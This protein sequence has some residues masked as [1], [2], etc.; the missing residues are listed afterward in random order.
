MC[1]HIWLKIIILHQ[2]YSFLQLTD[3]KANGPY[4]VGWYS[5]SCRRSFRPAMSGHQGWLGMAD[6]LSGLFRS[7]PS[8]DTYIPIISVTG[9]S[10]DAFLS[11]SWASVLLR[12]D[13]CS[14]SHQLCSGRFV[15]TWEGS[16]EFF[17]NL[18]PINDSKLPGSAGRRMSLRAWLKQLNP[19]FAYT[20]T[21]LWGD[22]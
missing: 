12:M 15:S 6:H 8:S 7:N 19:I 10:A 21:F 2:A 4:D 17:F 5:R 22:E 11:A 18:S 13:N 9:C 1:A 20:H 14:S 16:V 3:K